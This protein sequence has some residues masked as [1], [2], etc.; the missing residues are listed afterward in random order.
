MEDVMVT[1][2]EMIEHGNKR[3]INGKFNGILETS[4]Y[5]GFHLDA[6]RDIAEYAGGIHEERILYH[7]S[8]IE[9]K[10]DELL[11]RYRR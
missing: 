5:I 6:L 8:N 1:Y 10:I 9:K 2:E 11:D 3:E 7:I 4:R